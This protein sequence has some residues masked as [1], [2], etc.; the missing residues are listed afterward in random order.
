MEFS[1]DRHF[2]AQID[3]LNGVEQLDALIHGAL[4]GFASGDEAGTAG[5]LIDYG[6]SY[7]FLEVVGSRGASG[8]DQAGAAHETVRDLV[9]AEV[10]RMVARKVA[11]DALVEFAVARIAHIER[12]VTAV[13]FRQLLLDDVGLDGHAEVIGL[14][15]EVG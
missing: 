3:V 5:A 11:V 6:G 2:R 4:E 10:D 12:R 9:A 14:A 1:G 8:I 15:G 13:I 7:R